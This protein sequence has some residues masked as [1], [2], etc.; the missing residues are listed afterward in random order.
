MNLVLV[1]I[2]SALSA[3]APVA[4]EAPRAVSTVRIGAAEVPWKAHPDF[5]AAADESRRTLHFV[6][7]N[8]GLLF[9]TL[10]RNGGRTWSPAE[11]LGPGIAPRLALDGRGQLHMAYSTGSATSTTGNAV[12][13]RV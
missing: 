8:G 3:E 6:Y 9:Y 4:I 12:S 1:A 11:P 10:S 5:D 7:R 2:A 13:W